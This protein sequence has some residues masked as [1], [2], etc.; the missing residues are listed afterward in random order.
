MRVKER[1]SER[2]RGMDRDRCKKKKIGK[3]GN[4][5]DKNN[6]TKLSKF[7]VQTSIIYFRG[8]LIFLYSSF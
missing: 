6:L 3:I 2:E 5:F 4:L 8:S 1:K 7:R